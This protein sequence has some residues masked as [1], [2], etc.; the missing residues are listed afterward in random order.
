MRAS[1]RAHAHRRA[2]SE[3]WRVASNSDSDRVSG[4]LP[5]GTACGERVVRCGAAR[6]VQGAGCGACA[7]RCGAAHGTTKE[8][9]RSKQTGFGSSFRPFLLSFLHPCILASLHPFLASLHPFM[10]T[11][12]HA[13][14][15]HPFTC[16]PETRFAPC[17]VVSIDVGIGET[18]PKRVR[19]RAVAVRGWRNGA[20]FLVP[21]APLH[22]RPTG[23]A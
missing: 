9:L 23:R 20:A 14:S 16:T 3:R 21:L 5:R 15:F 17:E 13:S 22:A 10:I 1:A 19:A 2:T 18:G 7:M 11:S 6:G 12:F 4:L 8:A